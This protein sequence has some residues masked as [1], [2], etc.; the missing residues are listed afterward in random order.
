MLNAKI[1]ISQ[2]SSGE[3]KLCVCTKATAHRK[4]TKRNE[5]N[6]KIAKKLTEKQLLF[7]AFFC[8]VKITNFQNEKENEEKKKTHAPAHSHV[9][10][11]K[12]RSE[13]INTSCKCRKIQCYRCHLFCRYILATVKRSKR[14]KECPFCTRSAIPSAL[15]QAC[16]V[17]ENESMD[18]MIFKFVGSLQIKN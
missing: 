11:Y 8:L 17:R 15:S 9:H 10:E 13:L 16:H 1:N 4:R 18:L 14:S 6:E 2:Y 5:M 12:Q 3:S 7:L